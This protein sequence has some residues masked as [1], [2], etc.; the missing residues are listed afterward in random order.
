VYVL[1]RVVDYAAIGCSFNT[2]LYI[3]DFWQCPTTGYYIYYMQ[4]HVLNLRLL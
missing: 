4:K 3:S 2:C 1:S